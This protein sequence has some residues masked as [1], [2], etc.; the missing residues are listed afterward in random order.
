MDINVVTGKINLLIKDPANRSEK[1]IYV[2]IFTGAFMFGAPTPKK[3]KI[4]RGELFVRYS[5]REWPDKKYGLPSDAENFLS[6]IS[7]LLKN[8]NLE[9]VTEISLAPEQRDIKNTIT[10]KIKAALAQEI[11]DR[12]WATLQQ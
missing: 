8:V 9:N 6:E 3:A 12:G 4:L 10:L 11:L 5:T 1:K 2:K 7:N